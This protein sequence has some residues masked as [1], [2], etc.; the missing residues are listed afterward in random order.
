[1]LRTKSTWGQDKARANHDILKNQVSQSV[2]YLI[3]ILEG[4]VAD[5]DYMYSFVTRQ[6]PC[7]VQLHGELGSLISRFA[8]TMSP[9]RLF[10]QPPLSLVPEED[11]VWMMPTVHEMW[12][13]TGGMRERVEACTQSLT[14]CDEQW[15]ALVARLNELSRWKKRGGHAVD[16]QA[17]APSQEAALAASQTVY[18]ACAQLA[19]ALSGL[20]STIEVSQRYSR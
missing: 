20:P 13:D 10:D 15:T 12:W 4:R 1:M 14:H 19:I 7:W 18:H 16:K 9:A 2:L 3:R 6:L 5:S 17:A 8:E 11:R